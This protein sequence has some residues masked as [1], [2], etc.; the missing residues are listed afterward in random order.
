LIKTAENAGAILSSHLSRRTAFLLCDVVYDGI[1]KATFPGSL[2]CI[3]PL[4]GQQKYPTRYGN[5]QLIVEA[6]IVPFSACHAQRQ[7]FSHRVKRAEHRH[8][9]GKVSL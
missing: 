2:D 6:D 3:R 1:G 8:R 7:C 5:I 9:P 4:S